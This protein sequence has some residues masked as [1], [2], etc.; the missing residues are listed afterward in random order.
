ML[1]EET[2]WQIRLNTPW[3][4]LKQRGLTTYSC[5][6][7]ATIRIGGGRIKCVIAHIQDELIR[8]HGREIRAQRNALPNHIV[9]NAPLNKR[10]QTKKIRQWTSNSLVSDFRL[11]P[12]SDFEIHGRSEVS[13]F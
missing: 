2:G 12:G 9:L 3:A 7:S 6:R 11:M 8:S 13:V 5:P 4:T 10:R 1:R